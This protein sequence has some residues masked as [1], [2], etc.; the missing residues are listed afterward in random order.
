MEEGTVLVVLEGVVDFLVPDNT[1][2]RGLKMWLV[3]AHGM[4]EEG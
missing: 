4:A 3:E 2:I 1:A